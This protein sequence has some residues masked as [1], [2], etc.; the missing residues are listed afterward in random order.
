METE[1]DA[2]R[3]IW[4]GN[5]FFINKNRRY[6]IPK[7]FFDSEFGKLLKQQRERKCV[8]R[9]YLAKKIGCTKEQLSLFE[10]GL[11]PLD[12][13][14]IFIIASFL[15]FDFNK[16]FKVIKEKAFLKKLRKLRYGI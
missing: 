12:F 8:S 2:V 6:N 1:N 14:K 15:D 9:S 13:Y 16:N 3:N 11:E 10:R 4:R 5:I 7:S